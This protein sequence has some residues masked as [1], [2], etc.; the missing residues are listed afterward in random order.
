MGRV[1]WSLSTHK[2]SCDFFAD[3]MFAHRRALNRECCVCFRNQMEGSREAQISPPPLP[4][5]CAFPFRQR[6]IVS[7]Q[8]IRVERTEERPPVICMPFATLPLKFHIPMNILHRR[9]NS[10]DP[11]G[12]SRLPDSSDAG[13]FL[14]PDLVTRHSNLCPGTFTP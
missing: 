5:L 1:W 3:S 7:I 14:Y 8:N 11:A 13:C 10:K 6:L 2:Q 9:S 12:G 4:S